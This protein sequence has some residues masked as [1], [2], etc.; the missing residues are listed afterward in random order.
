MNFI[1]RLRRFIYPGYAYRPGG[2]A[3]REKFTN[4][5]TTSREMEVARLL[6]KRMPG[7][8]KRVRFANYTK[9]DVFVVVDLVARGPIQIGC[10][11]KLLTAKQQT[12]KILQS[13][14]KRMR[15]PFA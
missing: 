14:E 11:S 4:R 7:N 15:I 3:S 12:E 6:N 13:I 2:I 1:K 10:V 5:G 9:E 8:I